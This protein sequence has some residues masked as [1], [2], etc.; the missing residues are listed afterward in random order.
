MVYSLGF[1]D[2]GQL[3]NGYKMEPYD[4]QLHSR[5]LPWQ[6]QAPS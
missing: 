6:H 2:H 5:Y 1:R 3:A 4:Y